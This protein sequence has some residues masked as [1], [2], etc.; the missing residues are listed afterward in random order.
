MKKF[1]TLAGEFGVYI[2]SNSRSLINYGE[3]C[4]AGE[5]ISAAFVEATVNSV[6]SKRLA[7]K[8]QMQWT[9]KGAHML[10]QT[11]TRTLEG[12]LRS[13]FEKWHPG[14][15]NANGEQTILAKAA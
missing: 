15:A 2:K 3:R 8:Q 9:R 11:R 5:R 4:R 12:T 7:Q 10:M 6:V 14:M 1:E 13:A